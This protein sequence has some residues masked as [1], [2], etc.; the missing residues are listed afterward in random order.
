MHP[1]KVRRRPKPSIFGR[2]ISLPI[3]LSEVNSQSE[4]CPMRTTETVTRLVPLLFAIAWT[5]SVPART[6]ALVDSPETR[7]AQA[8]RYL[9][10]MPPKDMFTDLAKQMSQNM[11][12]DQARQFQEMMLEELDLAAL[13]KAMKAAM[14]RNFTAA[15]LSALA[16]FYGSD[17]GKSAM[18]KFGPYMLDLMPAMQAQILKVQA[19]MEKEM[20]AA[21]SQ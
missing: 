8:D 18:A 3:N 11:P 10:A 5:L 20:G 15:E 17:V 19:R 9:E 6:L 21:A 4:D 16:D 13:Q 12:P 14:I 7:A 1:D 2:G